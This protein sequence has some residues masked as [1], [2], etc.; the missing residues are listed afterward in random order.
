MEG[1][2]LDEMSLKRGSWDFDHIN[3]ESF[4]DHIS[5][6]VPG[7]N[8]GHNYICFLSDYF[9]HNDSC[10][11]DIGCSTGNLIASISDYHKAKKGLK[12]YGI[13]PSSK[14][15]KN[16][17]TNTSLL[18]QDHTIELIISM[19]Q[20]ISL[21]PCDMVIAYY[22]FQFIKPRYRQEIIDSIYSKLNWGGGFFLFEK[23]RGRDARFQDMLNLAY[24]EYKIN[25][26]HTN[27]E[28][29]NKMFSLKGNLEPYT[30]NENQLFLKR[31]G[32]KDYS[33]ISK[34]LCFEGILA[35]K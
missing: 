16:F 10:I 23:I 15:E 4:E 3:H 24:L 33:I 12:F 11:Y 19:V 14:F 13:E 8:E 21:E 30:S 6:S 31:A 34:N 28:I 7:Y 20:D 29:M 18:N 22:T 32:F 1:S 9:I 25:N 27:D 5:K 26:G 2:F 17:K 35:I